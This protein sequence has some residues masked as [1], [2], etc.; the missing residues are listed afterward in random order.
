MERVYRSSVGART[1]KSGFAETYR[2]ALERVAARPWIALAVMLPLAAVGILA[3]A[4]LPS[5]FM[6]KLDEGGFILDYIASPG[7]SLSETDRLMR[8]IE[9]VLRATPE[10]ATYSRRTGAQLGGDLTESNVG[11]FFVRLKPLPRRGI[12]AVMDDVR[13]KISHLVPG[14]DVDTAQLMEDLIGDLTAV[15][16]PIEVKLYGEDTARLQDAARAVAGMLGGVRGLTEIRDGIVVAGDALNVHIDIA[17]AALEGITPVEA[18]RQISALIEGDI[19]TE[20]QSGP[21]LTAVRL[22]AT[23]DWRSQASK[24]ADL[25]L[26]AADGHIFPLAHIATVETLRGQAELT[27]ENGRQMIAVTARVEGRDMGS[28]A[29]EVRRR[30]ST[31]NPLPAGVTFD[32]GGLFA[33]QQAAFAGLAAVFAAALAVITVLLLF[34]YENFRIVAAIVAMPLMAACFVGA[35]LWLTGVELNIMALMGL[36]MVIG[37]VT[38]VAIFYFTEFEALLA[39]G[40]SAGQALIDAGANRLR[41]IA[42]T[43]L[44]AILALTPL[45]LGSSMQQPLAIAI[46]AGLVAQGPLVLLV[47]PAFYRFIGGI[48]IAQPRSS[49]RT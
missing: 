33:E 44:A 1:R 24:I 18:S 22:V 29:K 31:A 49:T 42:M 40:E 15:P 43:T 28:A 17:R 35:A 38:E 4:T 34:I 2:D 8:Q 5:G 7:A 3:F 21:V 6:P 47:M 9:T 32:M 25:P 14:V 12:D 41:P 39:A 48:A 10:V 27:R 23:A 37:I 11:D 20:V 30:L 46:I 16:Q 19:A 45:A 26:R 36:T 13:D